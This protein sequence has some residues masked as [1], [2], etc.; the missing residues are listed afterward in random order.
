MQGPIF[1][2]HYF[3]MIM[4][5]G[6]RVSLGFV[7]CPFSQ[8]KNLDPM[9]PRSPEMCKATLSATVNSLFEAEKQNP[10]ESTVG[11]PGWWVYEAFLSRCFIGWWV[12]EFHHFSWFIIVEKES[13]NMCWRLR[14]FMKFEVR[15]SQCFT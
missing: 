1:H 15:N 6:G 2:S 13:L 9:R 10:G 14:P 5:M 12:Y 7:L 8:K 11:H 4:I 3:S